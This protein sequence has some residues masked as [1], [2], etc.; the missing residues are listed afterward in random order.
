MH[1]KL[2]IVGT[3]VK[4]DGAGED[5]RRL[6]DDPP[7]S[8]PV[9]ALLDAKEEVADIMAPIR[10]DTIGTQT[11]IASG[12]IGGLVREDVVTSG[13]LCETIAWEGAWM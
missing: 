10:V 5:W 3:K 4:G 9:V 12:G 1:C 2:A 7:P 11:H 6:V 8:M 13:G